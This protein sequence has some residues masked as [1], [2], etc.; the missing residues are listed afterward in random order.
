VT[1]V[2]TKTI[3]HRIG[4]AETPG[5]STRTAPVWNPATGEQQ[6]EV[7]L[8]ERADVDAAVAA[9]RSRRG[10]MSPSCAARA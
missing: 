4:G 10:A 9:A 3:Q 2:Q 1:T 6:A 8:A 7:L 5:G